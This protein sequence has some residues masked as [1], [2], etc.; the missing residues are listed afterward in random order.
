ML[1]KTANN[2]FTGHL[3]A[4]AAGLPV[5][6]QEAGKHQR[7]A[8]EILEGDLKLVVNEAKTHLT[9]VR[10]GVTYLGFVIWPK[11]VSIHPEKVRSF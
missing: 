8:A 2:P 9:S 7:I 11:V 6:R 10:K 1:K 4:N 3:C 5:G